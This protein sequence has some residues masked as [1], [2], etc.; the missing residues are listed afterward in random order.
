MQRKT[1]NKF[2]NFKIHCLIL[3]LYSHNP[4][5]SYTTELCW[6]PK[7]QQWG[8]KH[9]GSLIFSW[10]TFPNFFMT[11]KGPITKTFLSCPVFFKHQI[12]TLFRLIL[13][14]WHTGRERR[15]QGL[16]DETYSIVSKT[17]THRLMLEPRY[18]FSYR[19]LI[20]Y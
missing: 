3:F 7:H 8:R 12:L 10:T 9:Q 17:L 4:K 16:Q 14:S 1:N 18:V 11:F 5:N 15:T 13:A 19:K 6:D 20:C 2:D